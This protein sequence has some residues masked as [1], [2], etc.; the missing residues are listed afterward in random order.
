M[1]KGTT[2]LNQ[3]QMHISGEPAEKAIKINS[4]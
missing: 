3:C 4:E 2:Q 1:P